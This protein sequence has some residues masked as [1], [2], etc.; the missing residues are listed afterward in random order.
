MDFYTIDNLKQ[1]IAQKVI[2][3]GENVSL[4]VKYHWVETPNNKN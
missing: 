3:N 4:M 1:D 2:Y